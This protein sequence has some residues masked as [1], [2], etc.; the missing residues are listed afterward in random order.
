MPRK[1]DE[2][3]REKKEQQGLS[4]NSFRP[5]ERDREIYEIQCELDIAG[6]EHKLKGKETG[7]E[8]P[9]IVTIDVS[10]RRVLAIT[11]NFDEDDQD[12]PTAKRRFVK[13]PFVPGLGF[14]GIG[15]LH[16]LGN[17]TNA[18]TAAWRE[19]LDNGMYANFPGFLVSKAG[20]RQNTNILRVPPGGSAQIIP[21]DSRSGSR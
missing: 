14:Y 16:I 6:F 9:Y 21:G 2:L 3:E 20:T 18:V 1:E 5:E 4:V 7:L 12:M 19:M 15:L 11:R 17:T 8:I 13:F 10:S